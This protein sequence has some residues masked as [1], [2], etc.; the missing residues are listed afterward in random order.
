MF[1]TDCE[2]RKFEGDHINTLFNNINESNVKSTTDLERDQATQGIKS[3]GVYYVEKNPITKGSKSN[4]KEEPKNNVQISTDISTKSY[5]ANKTA[6]A[7]YPE[8]ILE[9]GSN[10][11]IYFDSW[12]TPDIVTYLT[13]LNKQ[14]ELLTYIFFDG[15]FKAQFQSLNM[16]KNGLNQ[17]FS[18]ICKE[19][20]IEQNHFIFGILIRN[21]L[22]FI[23]P[24][25]ET[26]HKDFYEIAALIKK[27]YNLD[28]YLSN[29]II[30]KDTNLG[31]KGT[32]S[33]G[34]I[35]VE[36]IRYIST[37]SEKEILSYLETFTSVTAQTKHELE[38]KEINIKV[39]LPESLNSLETTDITNYQHLLEGIR[40]Q[41]L[42]ILAEDPLITNLRLEE[43]KEFLENNCINHPI[44]VEIRKLTQEGNLLEALNRIKE[45][46]QLKQNMSKT[47]SKQEK[48]E[49]ITSSSKL[50]AD[51]SDKENKL[52]STRSEYDENMILMVWDS[53]LKHLAGIQYFVDCHQILSSLFNN[54]SMAPIKSAGLL[55]KTESNKL[56]INSFNKSISICGS[57]DHKENTVEDAVTINLSIAIEQIMLWNALQL[58]IGTKIKDHAIIFPYHISDGHW[59][60]GILELNINEESNLT[61][62]E[63]KVFNPCP[64]SCGGQIISS[65]AH[66]NIQ[67]LLRASF[68]NAEVNLITENTGY[69]KQQ[70][71]GVSCGVIS[72]ENGKDFL[73]SQLTENRLEQIYPRGAENLRYNHIYEVS[74][75][76]FY[77]AQFNKPPQDPEFYKPRDY[78]ELKRNFAK[79][80]E[81]LEQ[82]DKERISSIIREIS[83]NEEIN[84]AIKIKDFIKD[85]E[86]NFQLILGLFNTDSEAWKFEGDHINTLVNIINESN[87]KSTTELE[88]D[89]VTQGIK[90]HGIDYVQ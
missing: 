4:N 84:A 71:D 79:S 19:P 66:T 88:G 65:T 59:A 24:V 58:E 7:G 8:V 61:Y 17:G 40:T 83:K 31:N 42:N 90:S 67:N 5:S 81:S 22:I 77:R 9:F 43:R 82:A 60:L 23:N 29:T 68:D 35:C 50:N 2:D 3:H 78:Q 30:Q 74:R 56:Y 11:L 21:Q 27:E 63:V 54:D 14:T 51:Y 13:H 85:H 73:S 49:E 64:P 25:G 16:L 32:F 33:C 38:Y 72:A 6:E 87:I 45:Y 36:L 10:E 12:Y 48:T 37:L 18:F 46:L 41:H 52:L 62:A 44:Q 28:F 75:D 70:N 57:V 89:Q 15:D 26:A 69:N 76:I 47:V 39:L 53:Y 86:D 34:P 20:G 55:I 80:I 1:K